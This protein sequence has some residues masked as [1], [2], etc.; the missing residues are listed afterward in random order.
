MQ[1]AN[2]CLVL[3]EKQ[4][5]KGERSTI[6]LYFGVNVKN[7]RE[8]S[9]AVGGRLCRM[10]LVHC[11]VKNTFIYICDNGRVQRGKKKQRKR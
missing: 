10:E 2:D 7:A 1:I 3:N 6:I 9:S 11:F 4:K 8:S 5:K